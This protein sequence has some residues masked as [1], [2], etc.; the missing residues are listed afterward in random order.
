MA[1]HIFVTGG[2]VS[3]LGKGL[4]SASVGMLLERRGMQSADAEVRPVHQRRSRHDVARTSTAKSTCSTTAPR[5][6]STSAIT[7]ASR[8]PR[9]TATA[10]TRPARFTC[11]SSGRS[12][13]AN[14]RARRC[15]SSRTSPTKSKRRSASWPR[16]TSDVVITE[17]GG[18]VGDIEGD[19]VPRSDPPIRP[20]NRQG[21]LPVH[22]PHA[23]AVSEGRRAN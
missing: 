22:S 10:I 23:R 1:K 12:A 7:N 14:T 13:R 3:S 6:I 17:I 4:T 9:S 15:R 21:E 16:P 19:A 18:T 8:T 2:V 11:R 20:R 5:P